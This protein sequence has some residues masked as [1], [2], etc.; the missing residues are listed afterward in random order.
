MK[1]MQTMSLTVK[2]SSELICQ[3]QI[4]KVKE[5]PLE[6]NFKIKLYLR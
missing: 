2:K 4:I 3:N 5:T 6:H 1:L